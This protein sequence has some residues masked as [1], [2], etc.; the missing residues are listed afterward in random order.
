MSLP[1]LRTRGTNRHQPEARPHRC[2]QT[3]HGRTMPSQAGSPKLRRSFFG[4]TVDGVLPAMWWT[5]VAAYRVECEPKAMELHQSPCCPPCRRAVEC[6]MGWE[7]EITAECKIAWTYAG[8]SLVSFVSS[9]GFFPF[10]PFRSFR[11]SCTR[12]RCS[13][14]LFSLSLPVY[15]NT[16]KLLSLG[17]RD[18]QSTLLSSLS[19]GWVGP[20]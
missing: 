1:I 2:I 13:C 7:T 11:L 15:I 3:L 9:L 6:W 19:T 10:L 18:R 17:H 8:S 20:D 4:F 12:A 14:C 5:V 16:P